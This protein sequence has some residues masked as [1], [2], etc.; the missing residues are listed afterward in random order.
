MRVTDKLSILNTKRPQTKGIKRTQA[1]VSLT[2]D[3]QLKKLTQNGTAVLRDMVVEYVP[4]KGKLYKTVSVSFDVPSSNNV[5]VL[6]V[7]ESAK[8]KLENRDLLV[9]VRH[10]Q[11]DRL[12]SNF[13]LSE[14][15]KQEI[16]DYLSNSKNQDSIIRKIKSLSDKTDDYYNSL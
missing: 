11:R 6:Y 5:T 4:V 12:T 7:E 14:K 10:K 8:D 3:E 13:L 15:K 1:K 16:V 2:P 9:G